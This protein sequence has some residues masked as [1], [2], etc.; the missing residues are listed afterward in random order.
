MKKP[1][2]WDGWMFPEMLDLLA[3]VV[4]MYLIYRFLLAT[5]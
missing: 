4:L 1:S 2:D 3:V 5:S